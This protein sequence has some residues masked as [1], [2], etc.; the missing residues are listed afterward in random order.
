MFCCKIHKVY[1]ENDIV[2]AICDKEL[3]G[4]ELRKNPYF[5]VNEKFYFEK[6]CNEEEAVDLLKSCTIANLVGKKIVE[7]ALK[8]KFITKENIILIGDIPHA[9][10]VK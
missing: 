3:I 9:Q 1:K 7:L 6:D 5:K 2:V 8:K 10:I 4:K